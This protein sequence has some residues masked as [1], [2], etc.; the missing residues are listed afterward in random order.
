MRRFVSLIALIISLPAFSQNSKI[1][2]RDSISVQEVSS[3]F[4]IQSIEKYVKK[5]DGVDSVLFSSKDSLSILV[6]NEYLGIKYA[7]VFYLSNNKYYSLVY[8]ISEGNELSNKLEIVNRFGTQDNPKIEELGID[9]INWEYRLDMLSSI[10]DDIPKV[11]NTLSNFRNYLTAQ[12]AHYAIYARSDNPIMS[13]DGDFSLLNNRNLISDCIIQDTINSITLQKLITALVSNDYYTYEE[14]SLMCIFDPHDALVFYN[15][16]GN[17]I[18]AIEICFICNQA[19]LISLADNS[20]RSK[21]NFSTN[22][23]TIYKPLTDNYKRYR[24]MEIDKTI[25]L[26]KFKLNYYEYTKRKN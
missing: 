19:K 6:K 20:V 17:P 2:L 7:L 1:Y 22:N 11:N 26:L 14:T 5:Q 21:F 3:Y 25:E 13:R 18:A 23:S 24:N 10:I 12:K 9:W 15:K 8:S 4:S 16:K